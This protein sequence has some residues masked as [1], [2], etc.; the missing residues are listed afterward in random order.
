LDE[1]GV[2]RR[3]D[4]QQERGLRVRDIEPVAGIDD[5]ENSIVLRPSRDRS[6]PMN[7]VMPSASLCSSSILAAV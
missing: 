2:I 5:P 1:C 7:H 4:R 3:R 6:S